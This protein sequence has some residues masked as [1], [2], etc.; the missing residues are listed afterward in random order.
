M[1][2]L[3]KFFDEH[4]MSVHLREGTYPYAK[5]GK[6][7]AW[8]L[9]KLE[10]EFLAKER[11]EAIAQEII[12]ATEE[13]DKSFI[14]IARINST[15]IQYKY[16]RVVIVRPPVSDG[17]EI[18]AVKPLVQLNIEDYDI[19]EIVKSRL[20]ERSS[21]IIISGEV[22]SGKSTFAAALAE[23]Y[24][25]IGRITKTLES[26][27]DLI[28]SDD[29]TQYSKNLGTSEEIHDILF[30]TRPDNVIFDEM[31]DSPDFKLYID[32]R[33]GGSSVI[34]VLHAAS[35]IDTIQRFIGRMDVGMIPSVLDTIIFIN[36][37][38]IEQVFVVKMVV[39][40]PSG[41]MEADLARPVIEVRDLQNDKLMFEIYSYGE[42]TVV[43]PVTTTS[44]KSPAFALAE[45]Q[46][47]K[48]FKNL[49]S[50]A[51][52]E[53]IGSHKVRVY[54][55][56]G[57]KGKIIGAKGVNINALEKKLGISI[58]V[59]VLGENTRKELKRLNY[60]VVERGK[61]LIFEVGESGKTVDVF[62]DDNFLF[63]STTSKKGEIKVNSKSDIGEKLLYALDSGKKVF[64]KG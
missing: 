23:D 38:T 24:A 20:E 53:M 8:D 11:V 6:P 62:I 30:L 50:K 9:V 28:L 5:R 34:G 4:T 36:K 52:V 27:R 48:E 51:E 3:E 61:S 35:P 60:N 26:P 43:I 2:E 12:E 37:G 39:K 49:S 42:Q 57:E 40:V 22:G 41:M 47:E 44:S 18:T 31:R 63:T 54:V 32:I 25:K 13:D 15:I 56:K 1:I 45:K 16:F 17:W 59:Q 58:D 10:Q 7:G 55:P 46:I 14:E 64:I 19:P 21:G 33:L 29:I